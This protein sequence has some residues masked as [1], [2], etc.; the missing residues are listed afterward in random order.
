MYIYELVDSEGNHLKWGTATDPYTRFNGYVGEGLGS[1][2]M[3]VYPP[4]ARYQALGGETRGIQSELEQGRGGLNVRTET[5]AEM[6]QGADWS[7]ILEQPQVP[8]QPL[9]TISR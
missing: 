1:A 2:R 7:E 5:R 6:R 3:R 9:I 8:R 4:Q